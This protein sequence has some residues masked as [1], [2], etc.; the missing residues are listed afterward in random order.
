MT[1]A[2]GRL[3]DHL[4]GTTRAAPPAGHVFDLLRQHLFLLDGELAGEVVVVEGPGPAG[5]GDVEAGEIPAGGAAVAGSVGHDRGSLL[6]VPWSP[7]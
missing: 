1:P 7:G 4:D 5:D 2:S 6:F 3:G